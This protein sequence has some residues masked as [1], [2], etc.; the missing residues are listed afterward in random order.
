ML[1]EKFN[2]EI[3]NAMNLKKIHDSKFAVST[4][5]SILEG[6]I[7]F[8]NDMLNESNYIKEFCDSIQEE[9]ISPLTSLTTKLFDRIN[10]ISAEMKNEEKNYNIA[11]A[12]LDNARI[13]FHSAARVAE[14]FKIKCETQK[15]NT[16]ISSDVKMKNEIKAQDALKLAKESEN[17]YI[18]M[19]NQTNI[20]QEN[21]IETKKRLL[22]DVQ[23]LEE[24][25]G[26]NIK[27][28]LR[29]YVIFQVS[30]VRNLQYDIEKKANLMESINVKRDLRQF[31]FRNSTNDLP[32][33]KFEFVPYISSYDY[34]KDDTISKTIISN[35][36]EFISNVFFNDNPAETSDLNENKMVNEIDSIVNSTFQGKQI[37]A[38]YKKVLSE[39]IS[40]KKTRRMLLYSMNQ[41]RLKGNLTLNDVSY[42]AIGDI[43][44]E[45]LSVIQ[46]EKEKR[47]FDSVKLLMNLA[48]SLYKNA[49][50]P[51]KPRIFLQNY[52]HGHTIWYDEQF[53]KDLIEYNIIEEMHSQK[54]YNIY[55]N[56]T[57]EMKDERLKQIVQSQLNTFLYNMISFDI[58]PEI[59]KES[60]KYFVD[61]YELEEKYTEETMTI[62]KDYQ[63]KK[64]E[65]EREK[66]KEEEKEKVDE[67]KDEKKDEKVDEKKDEK[68]EDDKEKESVVSKETNESKEG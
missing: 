14:D 10:K 57:F 23:G 66:E 30:L 9:L 45:C 56:E 43:L 49:A 18:S 51:N 4:F 31:I 15:N 33:Y 12:K 13:K 20:A 63:D 19:I 36:K 28:S 27:D 44:L 11:V 3:Q 5:E 67:K 2:S 7:G 52:L 46:L 68:K 24:E 55:N 50:E 61:Y 40:N 47:D 59:M 37:P 41:H 25:L 1:T 65:E 32:P 22:N 39:F 29:K 64:E 6:V 54:S 34:D 58:K 8:K 38:E 53:W 26:E 21:Y 16:A 60:I 62:I 42:Q 48:T 35:V 17:L